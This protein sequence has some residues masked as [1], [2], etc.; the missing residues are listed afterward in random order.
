MKKWISLLLAA[1]LLLGSL[2]VLADDAPTMAGMPNPM[3]EYTGIAEIKEDHP[4]I[5]IEEP[6][7]GATNIQYFVIEMQEGYA[8]ADIRFTLDGVEYDY[9]CVQR[10]ED[11]EFF[12]KDNGY[13]PGLY[14]DFD[15]FEI[16][17][18]PMDGYDCNMGI[19]YCTADQIGFVSWYD[20]ETQCAYSLSASAPKDVLVATGRTL[21][22]SNLQNTTVAGTVLSYANDML[23]L[24]IW[25][26]NIVNIPCGNDIDVAPGDIVSVVYAGDLLKSPYIIRVNVLEPAG[27]FSGTVVAHDN[28][29]VTVKAKNGSQIIFTLTENSMITGEDTEIKNN[30]QVSITYSGSLAST[31]YAFEICIDVPGEEMDPSLI[32]KELSGTVIKLTKTT[33][34]IKTSKGKKYSFR[35]TGDTIYSGSHSLKVNCTVN[36]RYDGYAS[37]TPDAKEITVTKAAPKPTPTPK[38]TPKTRTV[39]G[40]VVAVCGIW[41]TLD[42]GHVYTVNTAHCKITGPDYCDVGAHAVFHYYKDG[43]DRI[44]TTAR[45]ELKVY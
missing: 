19:Y 40:T 34:T 6:P 9:R 17:P 29:S 36:V 41:I 11:D 1:L 12:N 4:E 15:D 26:G 38:P 16:E 10:D 23:R 30:A 22:K 2:S 14:Y 32:D 37:A 33:V 7:E 44:C 3:S 18:V 43:N 5:E 21:L 28:S 25:N 20:F 13:L 27:R 8:I 39:E 42:D 45:F 31:V 35:R 24:K